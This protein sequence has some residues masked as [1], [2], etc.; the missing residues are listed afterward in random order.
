MYTFADCTNLISVH[1]PNSLHAVERG[2]FRGCD[3]LK[4]NE[5]PEDYLKKIQTSYDGK[6]IKE[7]DRWSYIELEKQ[8]FA[9]FDF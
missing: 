7:N 9:N 1:F 4:N 2:A 6:L 8:T 3:M 5:L